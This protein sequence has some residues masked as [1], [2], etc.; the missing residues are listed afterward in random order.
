MP[1]LSVDV[2]PGVLR[3]RSR[4]PPSTLDGVR[5]LA[6]V[7]WLL[8]ASGCPVGPDPAALSRADA[9]APDGPRGAVGDRCR[10][11]ADCASGEV[12]A[13]DVPGG[14]YCT[15]VCTATGQCPAGS[16]CTESSASSKVC[17]KT[18]GPGT[19]CRAEH[20]CSDGLCLP[21]CAGDAD[22]ESGVCNKASGEC[23]ASRVANSCKVDLDC[24]PF[25]AFCDK[26]RPEGYCS[27]PCGGARNVSCP[28]GANC[29]SSGA[30]VQACGAPADCRSGLLCAP[31][32][33][34]VKSCLPACVSND[35]CGPGLRCDRGSGSCV[36][37]GPAAG[38]LGGNCRGN[39]DCA[40]VGAGAV[41][42]SDGDGFPQ[43]Y[44]SISCAS[45]TCPGTGTCVEFSNGARGCL[46]PCAA[47]A[48]CRG[49]YACLALDHGGVCIPRC[50]NDADCND[51]TLVCDVSGGLCVPKTGGG[52]STSDLVSLTQS[53]IAVATDVASARLAVAVPADAVSVTFVGEAVS[54]PTARVAIVNM[55]QS[56]DDFV[57]STSLF[58]FN[59]LGSQVRIDPPSFPGS[60]AAIYPNSPLAPFT[61]SSATTTVKVGIRLAATSPTTASV[62]AIIRRAPSRALSGGSIDLNLYF[63]G[64]PTLDAASARA[65]SRF[66]QMLDSVRSVWGKA[67]LAIGNVNYIDITGTDGTRFGD[68]DI[69]DLGELVA[70]SSNAAARDGALNVFFVNTITGGARAGYV[71]LGVA[72]GL[73]GVP[74][75]GSAGSGMAVTAGDF[76]QGLTGIAHTWAH[77]GG[78]WLGLFHTTEATGDAFDPLPDT[79]EC[80]RAQFDAN[81]DKTMQPSECLGQGADNLM[82]WAA[83]TSISQSTVTANQ[84]FVMLR[85]AVVR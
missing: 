72:A 27:L 20:L 58:E 73:P 40:A 63:V 80:A 35:D 70:L 43:G 53:P 4:P 38:A 48:D 57:T 42:F 66:K 2:T 75:R 56:S 46:S 64:L 49:G 36:A 41:C 81:A 9:A 26:T 54:D 24:G 7:A 11:S 67:G 37:G 8:L 12:C 78:H 61:P 60:F 84:S 33:G 28:D 25:P 34:G 79:P 55:D 21:R 62:Q 69:N 65:D 82:F 44:C 10:T 5:P 83:S 15:S 32:A 3:Y 16:A 30:C 19:S 71:I 6:L 23:G 51:P 22:C 47:A 14:G 45:G 68:L 18:C 39:G 76:P 29:T 17:I 31:G 77:E 74:I 13:A 52:G 59:S 1:G 85:S 50:S